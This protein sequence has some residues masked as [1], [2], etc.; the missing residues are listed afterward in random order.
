[1]VRPKVTVRKATA[2]KKEVSGR[3]IGKM[4]KR[5]R[6]YEDEEIAAGRMA[7]R[8]TRRQAIEEAARIC[9]KKNEAKK[10][11]KEKSRKKGK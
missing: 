2:G 1:M 11:A 5:I 7:P 6:D 9:M 3:W 10:A 4:A 8:L